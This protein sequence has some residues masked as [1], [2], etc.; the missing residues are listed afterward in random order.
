VNPLDDTTNYYSQGADGYIDAVTNRIYLPTGSG[1]AGS[2]VEATYK[3]A[4]RPGASVLVD[5]IT[6]EM[7]IDYT[8]TTDEILISYEYGDNV[9][10]WSISDSLS[11]GTE[12]Y[13]TYRYGALRQPLVDN[14][15]VLTSLEELATIPDALDRET[16]RN[17]VSGSLQSFIKGPTIPA[18]ELL[19]EAF[20]QITPNITESVFL[21]WILGRDSLHLMEMELSADSDDDLPTYAPGKFG[22]GLLL[23]KAGQTATIPANSNISFREGTWEAFVTPEWK[24]IDNDA[25]L[26]FD[27]L[28]DGQERLNNI[29][30]GADA[31]NPTEIPFSLDSTDPS[32]LGR[33]SNLHSATGYFI[34]FDT[35]ASKWRMRNRAPISESRLF[36]G[37]ITTSGEF[38]DVKVAS[39]AD[40]YDGYDGYEINEINDSLRS[41]NETIRFSFVVDGYDSLNMAFDA[42]DAYNGDIA[43]FD[44]IDFTSDDIHYFFD[45]GYLA[46]R[47]RMSLY[48]DGKGF[49]RYR[50]YDGI[51][52]VK[53]LSHNINDW[54]LNETHHIA[55]SWKIGTIEM[56]DE[57]HLFVDGEEVPNTYRFS[58]YLSVPGSSTLYMDEASEILISSVS[59][60]TIGGIDLSTTSGSDIVSSVGSDF[61]SVTVGSRFL[62]LD[63]TADGVATQT[64]PYVYV[65]SIPS[66]TSLQLETGP[67]GSGTPYNA[68]S[69]LDDVRFSV[70]P[71]TLETV[72][73]PEIE[74]IRVFEL[75]TGG[76]ETELYSPSTL[77][78]D[79]GFTEDGYNDIVNIYNGLA[80]GSSVVLKTYGLNIQRCINYAYVWPDRLTNLLNV[81]TPPPTAIS[82]INVT[83]LITR[84]TSVG[85]GTFALIATIVGG[86]IVPVLTSNLEFCQP[87]NTITG[88]RLTATLSGDNISFSGLNRIF[89]I[90]STSDGYGLETITFTSTGKQTTTG[91][92]TEITDIIA[93]FTPID[94]SRDA[95]SVEIREA[96]PINWQ[97]NDGYYAEIH[98]SVREQNGING[99]ATVGT[100]RV[101]DVSARFGEED[102]GKTF[103][104]DSPGSIAGVYTVQDVPLD[105]SGT[106]KDSD[107]VILDT[108]WGD[109]YSS[110]Q[111][112]LLTTSYG[113]SGFANGLLT[114]ETVGTGGDPFLLRSCWYEVDHPAFL[115]IPWDQI[116]DKIYVG[117][118]MNGENQANAV[119]DEMRILDELSVDTGLGESAPSSG[120]SITTDSL[121]VEEF[122]ETTQTLGLFHFNDDVTNSADFWSSF[123]GSYRQSENSV[124]SNFEQ[125][126][127]F[128]YNQPLQYDNASIFNNDEG[129]IE[130]W[131]SP[132]LDGYNDPTIRYYVDLSPDLQAAATAV[133]AL[134]VPLPSRA[135]SV[136]S[137]TITGSDTNYFTNGSLSADGNT[138]TLGQPLPGNVRD[139]T[140]TFVPIT[141]QGDRFSI[142]KNAANS[143]ILRVI[144]SGITYQITVPI[145]WKKNTWHRVFVG[146]DLNNL[147]NQDRLIMLVDGMETGT[148]QYSSDSVVLGSSKVGTRAARNI[149]TDINLVDSFNTVNIGADFAGQYSALARIDNMRFS[150]ELRTVTYLGGEGPGQLLGRD[151]IYTSNTDT[152]QPVVSDALTR[153]LL[154]F[155]TTQTEVENLITIRNATTGI[156][157]FFVEVIDTF[158][159]ADTQLAHDLIEALINR[160]KPAH[161]RA[162]VS[163]TK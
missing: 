14:F 2:L 90:G 126:G 86:H 59:S 101:R 49:L 102:I 9:L 74:R 37:R 103:N 8:Y 53:M 150:S 95:G 157:D 89:I 129:T 23:N 109:G 140:V 20:T 85:L 27:I 57:L 135:R 155:D 114:F 128:I 97:E 39:T 47:C 51:G 119:I 142:F 61:S 72:S 134:I 123:S 91:Y 1:I 52:R 28:F 71:L 99:T 62:I 115:I 65:R 55:T 11:S 108:T 87:S 137:V 138:V 100:G 81:V 120:R 139:V 149:M 104:I 125:S 63:S 106:V 26:T 54:G 141:S 13:V 83:N 159:L 160:I 148:A 82:K 56:K 60:P 136:S 77:T 45:T 116:P 31:A 48:K 68:V 58:G 66:P 18:I 131:I 88:R 69:T 64:S 24:G 144:A 93:S 73:D 80:V 132:I 118:D 42:Y 30:I 15:G 130:F 96:V 147:D 161:T 3:V 151:L 145:F 105:P 163:F 153:L 22:N 46:N 146:W 75:D 162:F 16:Y 143:L 29:F 44:G 124:N 133:S 107:T 94:S 38:H 84:R 113:D 5:Y 156:F 36:S 34:W 117:S 41:T 98:L 17:A 10:D 122:T 4:L 21:E 92:F 25:T 154:D 7:F 6:G 121:V 40:G 110:I 76:L 79:Y 35:S 127:V 33:P 12:Y 19:V 50:V 152:A 70:N 111:W 43:G 32:V 112:R 67:P 158:S 78:P